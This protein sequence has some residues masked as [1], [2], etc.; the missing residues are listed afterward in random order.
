MEMADALAKARQA[1]SQ[2]VRAKGIQDGRVLAAIARVPRHQFVD[3]QQWPDAY[4]DQPLPIGEGQTISQPFTVA[5]QTQWLEVKAGDRVL[6]I[7]TGSGYQSA[8]LAEMGCAVWSMERHPELQAR[9]ERVLR[10]LGYRVRL[11]VG[12]G[13]RGWPE[14]APFDAIIVTAGGREVPPALLEQLV[15]PRKGR[16]GGRLVIPLGGASEQIM[17]RFTRRGVA[18]VRREEAEV[19]RFVPLIA[20][21]E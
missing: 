15:W 3:P 11:R 19:F 7:G 10:A 2:Q 8:V 5:Y 4:E 9:A 1:L 6:E 12:D 20:G 17:T 18:D 14:E 13:T 16:P 21:D